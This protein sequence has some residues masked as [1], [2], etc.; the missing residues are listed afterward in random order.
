MKGNAF[1]AEFYRR[2]AL[3]NGT[4]QAMP[5]W[6]EIQNDSR[7]INSA[8]WYKTLLPPNKDASILDIGFGNGFFMAACIILGYRKI[9]GAELQIDSKKH[10]KEWSPS[11]IALHDIK[12]DI[13][14]FLAHQPEKYDFIHMSHV[15]EHIPK[16]SLFNSV[17]ALY[18]ALKKRGTLLIRCPNMEGPCALSSFY[19]SLA[20]EYGFTSSNLESLLSLCNFEDI[21]FHKFKDHDLTAK[22]NV[23]NILREAITL[24]IRSLHRL[25][26]ASQVNQRK[27]FGTELIV[28]ARRLDLPTLFKKK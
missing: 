10:I 21:N 2:I 25:F 8:Q 14:D 6:P 9:S 13:G 27:Q 26:C 3:K 20:H 19:V 11:V 16:Y 18:F 7:V 15:L 1:I 17:D 12:T 5:H 28:T 24:C 22:Q 4:N 23:A